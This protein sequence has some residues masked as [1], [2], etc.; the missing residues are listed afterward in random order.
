MSTIAA[1]SLGRQVAPGL[2]GL[3][4]LTSEDAVPA[5]G[6]AVV[7]VGRLRTTIGHAAWLVIETVVIPAAML[8]LLVRGGHGMPGLV[9]VFAWRSA[10]ILCRRARGHRVPAT[11]WMAFGMFAARTALG[12]AVT[13]VAVYLWQPIVMSA[14]MGA[15]F[16]VT[17]LGPKPLTMRLA[18]DFIHLP[19]SL[20]ATPRVR[21]LFRDL[22]MIWG[23]VHLTC[24]ATGAWAMGLPSATTVAV[25]GALGVTCTVVS[26]G[27][28][29]GW[30]L[31]RVSRIQGVRVRL[32][33]APVCP[34]TRRS[35]CHTDS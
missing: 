4:T 3:P 15:T 6:D 21:N 28:C 17:A 23:A 27:G 19:E 33:D 31:W 16:T 13:S 8:Y 22:A 12:L 26:V 24:A 1:P 20:A 7:Y 5:A 9:A 35:V 10:C 32:A 2:V 25:N 30:G 34:L 18:H 11:V 29:V 14:V